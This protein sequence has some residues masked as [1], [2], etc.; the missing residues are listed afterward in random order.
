MPGVH[1]AG[2]VQ[3]GATTENEMPTVVITVPPGPVVVI[4][5]LIVHR[6][7]KTIAPV[8][9][10]SVTVIVLPSVLKAL[11]DVKATVLLLQSSDNCDA[12]LDAASVT[13]RLN[14]GLTFVAT[15]VAPLAGVTDANVAVGA[16]GADGVGVGV[17]DDRA[18]PPPPPPPHPNNT[19]AVMKTAQRPTNLIFMTYLSFRRQISEVD[20]TPFISSCQ[21]LTD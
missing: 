14:T 18:P 2:A 10:V 4:S 7:L 17:V 12:S 3:V 21:G 8:V 1:I 5:P 9:G 13:D 15:S 19:S 20:H 6:S 11:A 16:S